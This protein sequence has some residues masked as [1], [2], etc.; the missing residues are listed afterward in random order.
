MKELFGTIVIPNA[1]YCEVAED[2][3]KRNGS[4]LVSISDW[5][6]RQEITNHLTVDVLAASV[7]LGEA[8]AIT[9]VKELHADL[10]LIDDKAGRKVANL[11]T[12]P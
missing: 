12:F 11:S 4:Q 3:K 9:L 6:L 7:D 1:V 5:I 8:E 10:L 2:P